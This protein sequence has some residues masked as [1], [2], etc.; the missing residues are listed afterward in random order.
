MNVSFKKLR[1]IFL[2]I[3]VI[4]IL[5][6]IYFRILN[7]PYGGPINLIPFVSYYEAFQSNDYLFKVIIFNIVSF[8]PIGLLIRFI[9]NE[10]P[11]LISVIISF[12]LSLSIEICQYSTNKGIFDIDDLI[13]NMIGAIIGCFIGTLLIRYLKS[14]NESDHTLP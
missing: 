4:L 1:I 14:N 8:I 9:I 10:K 7:Q 2:T 5:M 3:L 13:N 12:I 6:F 11:M